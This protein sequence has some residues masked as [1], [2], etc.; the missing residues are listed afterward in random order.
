MCQ[1]TKKVLL[2]NSIQKTEYRHRIKEISKSH[3][4]HVDKANHRK[5]HDKDPTCTILSL[6]HLLKLRFFLCYGLITNKMQHRSM[7]KGL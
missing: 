1:E 4:L 7:H 3:I 2:S 5:L 6:R